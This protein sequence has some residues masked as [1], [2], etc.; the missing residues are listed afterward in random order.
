MTQRVLPFKVPLRLVL[1]VP[2]ILQTVAAIGMT[3]CV[4][5]QDGQA[6][7]QGLAIDLSAEVATANQGRTLILCLLALL[8]SIGAAVLTDHWIL[9]PIRLV[10]RASREMAQGEVPPP[11]EP[12]W[13]NELGALTISFNQMVH[14][15]YQS[16]QQLE[17]YSRSLEQEVKQRT[18]T[19]AQ[20]IQERQRA[21]SALQ[22]ANAEMRVLFNAMP[23][24]IFV[25]DA[26][27]R[28][29]KIP[30]IKPELLYN[31][32]VDRLGKTLHEI[33]PGET[34]DLF[35]SYI[36][37]ALS[38]QQT[39]TI[40]YSLPIEGEELWFYASISP[41]N[42][43]Q[44][45]WV[46]TNITKRKQAEEALRQSEATNQALIKAIPDLLIRMNR[47]GIYLG[48]IGGGGV[49]LYNA[50]SDVFGKNIYEV[51]P[52][53][54][55]KHR[56]SYTRQALETGELQVYEYDLAIGSDLR[57]EEA[58]IVVIN[59]DEVLIM[60]RDFTDRKNTEA[61]LQRQLHRTLL[62]KQITEKIRSKLDFRDI[63]ET[64]TRQIG[65]AFQ[66]NRCLIRLHEEA[67][68]DSDLSINEYTDLSCVPCCFDFPLEDSFLLAVLA[69][70]QAI[71]CSDVY[72][73]PLLHSLSA[74]LHSAGIKSILSIITSY[75]AQPN[76]LIVLYQCD[77]FRQ[78]TVEE[79]EL[80][81]SIAAQV[82]IAIAQAKLL[83]QAHQKQQE[84]Q[85]AKE[86]AETANRAKSMFLASMSHELRT[87]LN[88]ILGFTQLMAIDPT[89]TAPQAENLQ[90]ISDSGEHLLKLINDVLD[91]SKIEAGKVTL[92]EEPFDLYALLDTL[93]QLFQLQAQAKSLTLTV[94]RHPQVSRY[95][96]ADEGKLRQVLTNL[97]DN[98]IKFTE[99]GGVVLRVTVEQPVG[100]DPQIADLAIG[101]IAVPSPIH[102][103]LVLEVEDT[104]AGIAAEELPSLFEPFVQTQTGRRSKKGTGLGLPISRKFVQLM[105]GTLT[106]Q[107]RPGIGTEFRCSLPFKTN[108]LPTHFPSSIPN[109]LPLTPDSPAHRVLVV[110]DGAINR[111]L[112][113]QL[114]QPMGFD[115][116][117]APNGMRAIEQWRS[118]QP[119]LI[120]LDILMPDINGYEVMRQ[121]RAEESPMGA[122]E[123]TPTEISDSTVSLAV[124][125]DIDLMPLRHHTIIIAL[126]ASAFEGEQ[127]RLLAAGC[128]GCVRKP[129]QK[130]ELLD[131]IRHHLELHYNHAE[132]SPTTEAGAER[133]VAERS[134]ALSMLE[135]L[136]YTLPLMSMEWV[137][138]LYQAA[139]QANAQQV[140][141]LTQDIP[142][143]HTTL[144]DALVDLVNDFR[145]DL[146]LEVAQQT[147]S[148]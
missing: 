136:T 142:D 120:L 54:M 94:E 31:A 40:E 48:L 4:S 57:H 75:Q 43:D 25:L 59:E 53:E 124:F 29:L 8:L 146:I 17:A 148:K 27:G 134:P 22:T 46:A 24:L 30:S 138:Q 55:A 133:A 33:L 114:L 39:I 74:P 44:V 102:A 15:I 131:K 32:E 108:S 117:E 76:G 121:I 1:V 92:I 9:T 35:L 100:A 78:W 105:G 97:I 86:A 143:R 106:V 36:R 47:D 42:Q 52:F 13:I 126:T 26:D 65:Q 37:Q 61:A 16:R 71:V 87:P 49:K 64:A 41:I 69:Q 81:E 21:E 99:T 101:S 104:G 127:D 7:I 60:V 56:M 125:S 14:E 109:L 45:I 10:N 79:I 70:D 141:Q 28:H 140:L 145:F 98:A 116:Q 91:L 111:Q 123:L 50:M 88:A 38:T 18:Q 67:L 119:H 85:Q 130:Q 80:L 135:L 118:W 66:V 128:D 62:L 5:W 89:T 11:I 58:R 122:L 23:E 77:R 84:L 73:E 51:L 2:F 137:H 113:M 144:R 103:S 83:E 139:I 82:G 112:L 6:T 12:G 110:D 95:F 90:I 3:A 72:T 132:L 68:A 19:L 34:S 63:F 115:L 20:Q 129:F 93:E 107:S 96:E 147:I